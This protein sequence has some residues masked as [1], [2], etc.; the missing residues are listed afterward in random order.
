LVPSTCKKLAF[1][2]I[3]R[4]WTRLCKRNMYFKCSIVTNLSTKQLAPNIWNPI[5]T[6]IYS[7]RISHS[8]K[9]FL[10]LKNSSPYETIFWDDES[11]IWYVW[12]FPTTKS[13]PPIQLIILEDWSNIDM[14]GLDNISTLKS[15]LIS[16]L[17]SG[18]IPTTYYDFSLFN[19]ISTYS[20]TSYYPSNFTYASY[21]SCSFDFFLSFL[22]SSLKITY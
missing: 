22:S 4:N 16:I 18:V 5:S 6:K 9:N 10:R 1:E 11:F 12:S 21:T 2:L 14:F 19:L 7:C 20:L 13:W 17:F 8:R 3:V 15:S